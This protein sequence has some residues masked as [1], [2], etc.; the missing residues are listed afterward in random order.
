MT[1]IDTAQLEVKEPRPGWKGRFFH[2]ENMTFGWY[3][4][5]E[6]AWIHE[7]RHENEE[8]WIVVE[9]RFEGTLDGEVH[10]ARPG[11]AIVVPPNRPHSLRAVTAGRALVV[12]Y[13]VRRTVGGVDT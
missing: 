6:G 10:E 4:V 8:V 5:D 9:G 1:L 2:S 11:C 7:H 13:P 12:D 3:E